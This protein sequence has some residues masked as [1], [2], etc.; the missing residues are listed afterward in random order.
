MEMQKPFYNYIWKWLI[1]NPE[2]RRQCSFLT[3]SRTLG[4]GLLIFR[5]VTKAIPKPSFA[6][7]GKTV[8]SWWDDKIFCSPKNAAIL[9]GA[10]PLFQVNLRWPR[11]QQYNDH[12]EKGFKTSEIRS[13]LYASSWS[14]FN[15]L[16]KVVSDNSS[17]SSGTD[18]L[19]VTA[20]CTW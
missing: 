15:I 3:I 19:K 4:S 1:R 12:V 14:D 5:L 16:H 11:I 6:C 7:D 9:T 20:I 18:R 17:N 8:S 2:L 10:K 13:S